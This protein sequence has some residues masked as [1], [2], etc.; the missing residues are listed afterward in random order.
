MFFCKFQIDKFF[1]KIKINFDDVQTDF[2]L[3]MPDGMEHRLKREKALLMKGAIPRIFSPLAF[4]EAS[5][6]SKKEIRN[7]NKI[8]NDKS[9]CS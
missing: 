7:E 8:K 5:K 9:F 6:K 4:Q 1:E 2:G 3:K